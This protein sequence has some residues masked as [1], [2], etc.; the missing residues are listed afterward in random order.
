[1]EQ[2]HAEIEALRQQSDDRGVL[3]HQASELG[4]TVVELEQQLAALRGDVARAERARASVGE[5][6]EEARR[7]QA[8]A[9]A[10]AEQRHAALRETLDRLSEEQRQLE[11][12]NA[13]HL[14]DADALRAALADERAERARVQAEGQ[15][16][17]R[18]VSEMHRR[19]TELSGAL[20]QRD[21]TVEATTAE[22]Q[23]LTAQVTKLTSQ[24]RAAQETLET[25]QGRSALARAAAESD[26]DTWKA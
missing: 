12:E 16:A 5:E 11:T 15:D 9:D 21:A 17:A 1:M 13:T 10:A 18:R 19:L 7:L 25:V 4:R 23:R 20:A 24:L 3:A 6:L 2:A 22:R 26:R 14:A 8:E